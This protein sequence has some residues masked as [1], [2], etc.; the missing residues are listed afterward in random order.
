LRE[1][2]V[3][4][5]VHRIRLAPIASPSLLLFGPVARFVREHSVLGPLATLAFLPP[6][7]FDL[8]A[9]CR[10]E[11]SLLLFDF[12]E[13]QTARQQPI[14]SLLPRRLAFYLN[15][16][17][18]VMQHDAGGGLVDV[19]ATVPSRPDEAFFDLAFLDSQLSHSLSQLRLFII[20]DRIRIH[21]AQTNH[22]G[23]QGQ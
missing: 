8:C 11:S 22:C 10:D 21:A 4:V 23:I 12:V 20:R 15:S 18:T 9:L 6:N 2:W 16:R 5:Q 7:L 3:D 13:Q 17:R 19:L 1:R 14:Q